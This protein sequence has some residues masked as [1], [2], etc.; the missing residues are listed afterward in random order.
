MRGCSL[1]LDP[2][3]IVESFG[4]FSALVVQRCLELLAVLR[5][6]SNFVVRR[7]DHSRRRTKE[8][9]RQVE[10]NTHE[11]VRSHRENAA[12]PRRLVKHR[13][14]YPRR[15]GRTM[16]ERLETLFP[17]M[18]RTLIQN[19]SFRLQGLIHQRQHQETKQDAR[20]KILVLKRGRNQGK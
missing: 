19:R 8:R 1:S 3:D 6:K 18:K 10:A 12:I 5:N 9:S 16:M 20:V 2:F 15:R 17:A 13:F 14:P 7:L 4:F 11:N